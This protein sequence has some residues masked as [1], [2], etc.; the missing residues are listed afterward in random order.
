MKNSY[1]RITEAG[2]IKFG[3]ALG[4]SLLNSFCGL[5]LLDLGFLGSRSNFLTLFR[6]AFV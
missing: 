5:C 6:R 4:S 1:K 2:V 3:R